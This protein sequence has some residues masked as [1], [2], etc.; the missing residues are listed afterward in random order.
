MEGEKVGTRGRARRGSTIIE[1]LPEPEP[2]TIAKRCPEGIDNS[3]DLRMV[4]DGREGYVKSTVS[5]SSSPRVAAVAAGSCAALLAAPSASELAAEL[6]AAAA[7]EAAAAAV[8]VAAAAAATKLFSAA[9]AASAA[10]VVFRSS[11]RGS[12]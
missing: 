7:A 11:G 8:V 10:A 9:A 5:K 1:L 4:A 12:K 2:P 6:A 3:S